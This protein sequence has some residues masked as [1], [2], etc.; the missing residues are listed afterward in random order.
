L[1]AIIESL[2]HPDARKLLRGIL[3]LFKLTITKRLRVIYKTYMATHRHEHTHTH[4]HAYS[5]MYST[6]IYC[7]L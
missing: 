7:D 4:T 5:N 1:N 3:Q 6:R 2:W